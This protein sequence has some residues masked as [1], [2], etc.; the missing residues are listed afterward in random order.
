MLWN[1]CY[2]LLH[3]I[4]EIKALIIFTNQ[5]QKVSTKYFCISL[6]I[7]LVYFTLRFC[8][9]VSKHT[10]LF[11][12]IDLSFPLGNKVFC[13]MYGS[14]PAKRRS[15]AIL[16]GSRP[17][18]ARP[19]GCSAVAST[20]NDSGSATVCYHGDMLISGWWDSR[21]IQYIEWWERKGN[22]RKIRA[23]R[24]GSILWGNCR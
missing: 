2:Q 10:L 17:L 23:K 6:N 3:S 22:E 13:E 4:F 5:E 12:Q 18:L 14:S 19:R 21:G 24:E 1:I 11:N 9:P 8:M 20:R 15:L 7:F 16:I